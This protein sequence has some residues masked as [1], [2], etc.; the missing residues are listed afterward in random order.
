M[1]GIAPA[2]A[3]VGLPASLSAL[4]A[5]RAEPL[6]H[7]RTAGILAILCYF[8]TVMWAGFYFMGRSNSGDDF[9]MSGSEMTAWIA[10]LSLVSAN[11]SAGHSASSKTHQAGAVDTGTPVKRPPS[12]N[13]SR[14]PTDRADD[15]SHLKKMRVVATGVK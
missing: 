2:S 6:A 4:V 10:G 11:H 15:L 14:S 9:F 7:L 12:K 8:A 1:F 3:A 13:G 5:F